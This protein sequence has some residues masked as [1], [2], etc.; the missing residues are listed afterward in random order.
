M[1][2]FGTRTQI[3]TQNTSDTVGTPIVSSVDPSVARVQQWLLDISE[4]SKT[5]LPEPKS[6]DSA[7]SMARRI[8][9]LFSTSTGTYSHIYFLA[10]FLQDDVKRQ[11]EMAK[12][13]SHDQLVYLLENLSCIVTEIPTDSHET[14]RSRLMMDQN[15]SHP[16]GQDTGVTGQ[17]HVQP[18]QTEAQSNTQPSQVQPQVHPAPPAQ[19]PK[20]GQVDYGG[21]WDTVELT[22]LE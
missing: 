20:P 9:H 7:I 11:Q 8:K 22:W 12:Q 4:F 18:V 14:K 21:A 1:T 19:Q 5:K 15:T 13:F 3:H 16:H 2:G 6:H 10:Y 17:T